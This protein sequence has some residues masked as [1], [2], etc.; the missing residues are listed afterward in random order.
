MK[1]FINSYD[2]MIEEMLA[3][4]AAA[5][6]D[7]VVRK[8]ERVVARR[9]APVMGKVGI[10]TGGGSGHK[11]ALIGY[12]GSGMMD[13]V[14]VGNIF[15]APGVKICYDTI[16]AADG[17]KGVLVCIGNYSGDIMNFGMAV[18]MVREEGMEVE[19]VVVNDDVASAP[20][21]QMQNRR[22]VAGEIILWKVMGAMA[23]AGADVSSMKKAADDVIFRTRSLGVAHS[24][25]IMPSSGKPSFAIGDDEM[26]IGVGHHGEPGIERMKMLGADQV[27]DIIMEKILSDLPFVKKDEV[28]VIVNGL[29][30]TALLELYIIYRRVGEILRDRGINVYKAWVGE[31]F[32]SMEMGGFSITLTRLN[33]DIKK[34]I[35][36]PVSAVHFMQA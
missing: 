25:C 13:A 32:T 1:K 9:D 8:A 30:S 10:I 4:F 26:E 23:D 29:G 11:P 24:P 35:D 21:D 7:K 2:T 17:G 34:C 14:A 36:H 22:G 27:T 33:E 6:R 20:N 19:M 31:F 3:G 16:K 12:I 5:N 28:S 18:D 15:A